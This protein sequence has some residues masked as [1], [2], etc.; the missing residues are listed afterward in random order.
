MR[1][2]VCGEMNGRHEDFSAETATEA[3]AYAESL[4]RIGAAA[5][6]IRRDGRPLS[7]VHEFQR[8]IHDEADM[9]DERRV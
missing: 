7:D 1:F 9:P 8:L 6:H 2:S 4:R 5:I 3:A